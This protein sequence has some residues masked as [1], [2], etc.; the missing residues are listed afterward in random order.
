[1]LEISVLLKQTKNS[2]IHNFD[3]RT[4]CFLDV[5]RNNI[6]TITKVTGVKCKTA[7]PNNSVDILGVKDKKER[8]GSNPRFR[9]YLK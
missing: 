1:M 3:I 5:G 7:I 8:A 9:R 6:S 4:C 2:Y